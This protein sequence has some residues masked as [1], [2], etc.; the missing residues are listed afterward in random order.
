LRPVAEHDKQHIVKTKT[1]YKEEVKNRE[2]DIKQFE[3]KILELNT[4]KTKIMDA[5]KKGQANIN[6]HTLQEQQLEHDTNR[7]EQLKNYNVQVNQD[8]QHL[9]DKVLRQMI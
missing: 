9:T 7:T 6:Q 4:L 8:L 5:I 3:G 1:A 2:I